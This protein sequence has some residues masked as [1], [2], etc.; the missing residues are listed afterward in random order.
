MVE[1]NQNQT[2]DE[3]ATADANPVKP[4]EEPKNKK[5]S[6]P[7]R[8]EL[9]LLV[10]LTLNFSYLFLFLITAIVA[11]ISYEAG[12][13]LL[14]IFLRAGITVVIIGTVL[15][16]LTGR[17]ADGALVA[18]KIEVEEA[19]EKASVNMIQEAAEAVTQDFQA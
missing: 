8:L 19:E 10:E 6:R 15:I 14:E 13:N 1:M 7:D 2:P 9:P 3:K 11:A 16:N 4:A 17:I 18:A 5:K 12:A